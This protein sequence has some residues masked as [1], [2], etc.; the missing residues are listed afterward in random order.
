MPT[1]ASTSSS[2]EKVNKCHKKTYKEALTGKISHI[3]QTTNLDESDFPSFIP[4]G[5]TEEKK[6]DWPSKV[7]NQERN[8]Q[9]KL[10]PE[11]RAEKRTGANG[12]G[13]GSG[14]DI[15][16]LCSHCIGWIMIMIILEAL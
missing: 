4:S 1:N 10:E 2:R 14:R 7:S 15:S 9:T 12:G 5:G 11:K 13:S 3:S 6:I 16:R 8:L